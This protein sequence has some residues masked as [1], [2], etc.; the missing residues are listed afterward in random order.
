MPPIFFAADAYRD[1]GKGYGLGMDPVAGFLLPG[2][3]YRIA[4]EALRPFDPGFLS[5]FM[6]ERAAVELA[7]GFTSAKHK[8]APRIAPLDLPLRIIQQVHQII[9][10]IRLIQQ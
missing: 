3:F 9:E 7:E 4:S 8:M 1:C 5:G 6:A 2:S 10:Q